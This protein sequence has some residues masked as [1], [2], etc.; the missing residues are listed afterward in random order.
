MAAYI[1][2]TQGGSLES[3]TAG[4]AVVL[5]TVSSTGKD[6]ELVLNNWPA[7]PLTKTQILLAIQQ[8]QDFVLQTTALP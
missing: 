3:P 2:I 1:G 6:V 8:L 5:S 7:T 4:M